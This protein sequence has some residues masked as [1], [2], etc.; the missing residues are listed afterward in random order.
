M[1]PHNPCL[2]YDTL[3]HIGRNVALQILFALCK[4][5]AKKY[6][7]IKCFKY[8]YWSLYLDLYP[9]GTVCLHTRTLDFC[10]NCTVII[11]L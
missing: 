1:L 5:S 3:A 4:V 2:V 9:L 10:S 6:I 7:Y 11:S 8:Y